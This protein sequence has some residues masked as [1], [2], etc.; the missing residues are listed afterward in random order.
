MVG[1]V[2][3][4]R[5]KRKDPEL[6]SII[7][8]PD[9]K[10]V[11]Q[12]YQSTAP[13]T[14][15]S[16]IL[17]GRE[18]LYRGVELISES[19]RL[20][21]L[22][23]VMDIFGSPLDGK[24]EI[25]VADKAPVLF[26]S[27]HYKKIKSEKS[28]WETGIKAIDFFSP[29]VRGGRIGLFGGA[30]VGKTILLA[31][32]LHNIVS[33]GEDGDGKRKKASVFAGVGERVREGHELY[34]ELEERG[35]LKD[36]ALIFGP[37]GEN[38]SVRFLTAMAGVAM[39]E[40]FRDREGL[41]VLF[42]MD[43]VYRFAQAGSELATLMRT[44][45]SEDGYQP[46]INS[47]MANF[48]ERLSSTNRGSISA[49]EAIYVPSDDLLDYGVQSIY[50]YLDST[51]AL[52]R[53]VYQEG[54]FPAIDLLNSSSSLISPIIVGE[55]HYQAVIEARNI[56]KKAENLERMV[57]LVGEAELSPENKLIYQRAKLIENYMTQPFFVVEDQTAKKGEFASL[58]QTVEDMVSITQGKA[59]SLDPEKL[60]FIGNLKTIVSNAKP[61]ETQPLN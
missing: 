17:T 30:G 40:H 23:R 46:T 42:L 58:A 52:S 37:M 4:I 8:S 34:H 12:V 10:A 9:K 1:Q 25:M 13:H 56:L 28:L 7:H 54:R 55:K 32:V 5:F 39:A 26:D 33:V 11:L 29:L 20:E 15:R 61:A 16:I 31:E 19:K 59:D 44:I 50:P 14:Y 24:G 22:G 2:A 3:E 48:H 45:P 27:P 47:E 51:I 60:L 38:A 49:I 36:V 18:L 35:V 57:T 6:F 43:N 41:E 21:N 53:D